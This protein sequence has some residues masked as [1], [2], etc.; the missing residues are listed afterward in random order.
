MSIEEE[1]F[2]IASRMLALTCQTTHDDV[3]I[4]T[5]QKLVGLTIM[6]LMDNGKSQT[7]VVTMVRNYCHDHKEQARLLRK[8]I[9]DE[10]RRRDEFRRRKDE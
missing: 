4:P 7:E 5:L 1:S 8:T 10:L 9:K 3:L 2:S 6:T